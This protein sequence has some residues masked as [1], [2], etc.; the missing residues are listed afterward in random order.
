M[1]SSTYR[2]T[3][4]LHSHQSQV[5]IPVVLG[6]TSRA[7]HISLTDG[8]VPYTIEDGCLAKISIK[9]P[10]GTTLEEF[11]KIEHQ[12]TIVYEFKQ[13]KNTAATAGLHKCDIVLY[14]VDGER[15]ASPKFSMV[16]SDRVVNKDDLDLTDDDHTV[17]EAIIDKMAEI[18]KKVTAGAKLS[19]ITLLA[20]AWVGTQSP[21][22]QVVEIE[23]VT[24]DSKVDLQ[25][26]VEQLSIFHNKDLGFVT[27]NED[28]VVTVYAIGDKP[29]NDY[30]IQV[31]ITEVS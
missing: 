18:E 11:C 10:T 1:N 30:T 19:S 15:I 17:I 8:G 28:G 6:D 14:G 23:G 22:S 9:R 20:S 3:L 29:T 24:E 31:T 7:F 27:E 16:V 13:N 21:Y 12:S 26:S 25:P 5:S 2:F 4:D